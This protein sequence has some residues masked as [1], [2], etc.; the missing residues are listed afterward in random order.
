MVWSLYAAFF[1]LSKRSLTSAAS[2]TQAKAIFKNK[3]AH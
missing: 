2:E 3:Q 1:S